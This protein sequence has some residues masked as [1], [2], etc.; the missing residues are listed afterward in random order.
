MRKKVLLIMLSCIFMGVV[1]SQDTTLLNLTLKQAEQYAIEHNRTMMNAGL[2]AKSAEKAK[3][4]SLATMLPQVSAGF[5]YQNYCGYE[6]RFGQNGISIPMNPSGTLAITAAVAVSGQQIVGLTL[7]KIATE[8]SN[9]N[10]EQTEMNIISQVDKIYI[11]TLALESTNQLLRNNLKN[12]E[13][14]LTMTQ[15]AVHAGSAEQIDADKLSIQVA[16]LQNTIKINERALE[17]LYNSMKLQLGSGVNTKIVLTD[18]IDDLIN[19]A[20][21]EAKTLLQ[22][23]FNIDDNVS[24]RISKKNL[25]M[26]N[27]QVT[28]AKMNILPTLSFHYSYSAKTYF[29]KSEG[30][31][32]TPPNLIGAS[33]KV[34][35]FSS[36]SN[37]SKIQQSKIENQKAEN[38]F[39]DME[40]ALLVQNKQLRFNLVSAM[41]SYDIQQ[42][43]IDVSKRMFDNV[44][45]KYKY[46][47]ASSLEVTNANTD[48]ITAQS[49]YIN[50]LLQL[51]QANIE[52]KQLFNIK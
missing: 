20:N 36:L 52:L 15:N 19:V 38:T 48:I 9:L 32:M 28:L 25:E 8:M 39:A 1:R 35:L 2:A 4:Q 5:D 44:S 24:Y 45:E 17:I 21:G 51:V 30:M 33:L 12:M 37:Y 47:M 31:N 14:L 22:E 6:M 46:G 27:R 7:S 16:T 26:S 34:P 13:D 23:K 3:W 41:E 10:I 50:A 11:S 43:N 29:G 42:K 49:N 40:D 18:K